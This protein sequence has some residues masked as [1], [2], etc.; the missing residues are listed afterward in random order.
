MKESS[1]IPGYVT[2]K[3]IANFYLSEKNMLSGEHEARILDL[4]VRGYLQV[5]TIYE[6]KTA[7]EYIDLNSLNIGTLPSDYLMYVRVGLNIGERW[8][9]LTYNPNIV[10]PSE[11]ECGIR[12]RDTVLSN[13]NVDSNVQFFPH[14]VGTTYV[15]NLYGRRGGH[16]VGYFKIDRS[17]WEIIVEGD[18]VMYNSRILLDYVSTGVRKDG[19]T[20][21]P[22]MAI[23]PLIAWLDWKLK[24]A[25]RH[26]Y[27]MNEMKEAE[28]Q[29]GIAL[30]EYRKNEYAFTKDDYLDEIYLSR[31]Q[32]IKRG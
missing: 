11:E 6:D 14:Y 12:E 28:N 30:D 7:T 20:K 23:E 29:Y 9:T 19:L 32:T 16:N 21:V 31:S 3:Q 10:I 15:S 4:L 1:N 8:W 27:H 24:V 22:L 13:N 17:R 25:D 5:V 2:L 26:A 18:L